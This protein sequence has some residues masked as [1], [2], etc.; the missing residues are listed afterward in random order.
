MITI[1]YY[2]LVMFAAV[3]CLVGAKVAKWEIKREFLK[4]PVT[5][6]EMA[7]RHAALVLVGEI[8]GRSR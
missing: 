7:V 2:G 4:R 1:S 3:W 5:D 8:D 6:R